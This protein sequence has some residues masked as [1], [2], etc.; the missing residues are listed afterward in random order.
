MRFPHHPIYKTGRL[1]EKE[2]MPRAGKKVFFYHENTKDTKDI[3]LGD[4]VNHFAFS[5]FRG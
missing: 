1:E 3:L 2:A 5:R 4:H